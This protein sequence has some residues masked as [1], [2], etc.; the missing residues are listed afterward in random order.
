MPCFFL[1]GGCT[2]DVAFYLGGFGVLIVFFAGVMLDCAFV[3]WGVL[4][5]IDRYSLENYHA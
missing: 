1:V 5:L 4:M 2:V 3:V